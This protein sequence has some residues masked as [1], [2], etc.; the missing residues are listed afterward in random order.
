LLELVFL[1]FER[2]GIILKRLIIVT[3]GILVTVST[4]S[5]HYNFLVHKLSVQTKREHYYVQKSNWIESKTN[6]GSIIGMT[7]A[8]ST[9]FFI[10]DRVIMNLDGLVNGIEYFHHLQTGNA[11]A[12]LKN[13]NVAYVFGNENILLSTD[14]YQLN[15]QRLLNHSEILEYFGK[16]KALW[17][18]EYSK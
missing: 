8:G 11:E 1:I 9:S 3:L 12:Y 7:G 2:N 10:E 16:N 13:N 18:I 5:P 6:P 4:I 15:F 17:E 14:P